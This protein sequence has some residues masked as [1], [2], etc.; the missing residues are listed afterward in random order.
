MFKIKSDKDIPGFI[1]DEQAEH[2]KLLANSL[3]LNAQVLEIGC[4]WGRSTWCWL[5]G[6]PNDASLTVVDPFLIGSGK[7]KKWHCEHQKERWNHKTINKIMKYWVA[8]GHESTWRVVIDHHPRKHLVKE[9]IV[10]KSQ[11]FAKNS[12][13]KWDCVFVDGDHKY[14][15]VKKDL[16]LLE[17]NTDILC[18]D[19]YGPHEPDVVRAVDEMI[20]ATGRTLWTC[21]YNSWF[22]IAKKSV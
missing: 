19:D 6:L 11:N 13:Q 4:A 17:P 7:G 21:P 1:Q 15:E 2:I 16:E 3:P 12:N 22:W 20:Q 14:Q 10:D 18:G 8:H 5:D 9:L